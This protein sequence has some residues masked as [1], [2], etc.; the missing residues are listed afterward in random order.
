MGPRAGLDRCIK[1]CPHQDS[2]PDHPVCSAETTEDTEMKF[3]S[4][5]YTIKI[6]IKFCHFVSVRFPRMAQAEWTL[7]VGW[8]IKVGSCSVSAISAPNLQHT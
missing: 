4:F 7:K 2:I 1:S 6:F 5:G 8:M 3:G